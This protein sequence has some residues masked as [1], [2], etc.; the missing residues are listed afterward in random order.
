MKNKEVVL[1]III[2][3]CV[4]FFDALIL[5]IEVLNSTIGWKLVIATEIA[6]VMAIYYLLLRKYIASM[7]TSNLVL[8]I[9]L[10]VGGYYAYVDGAVQYSTISILLYALS[11]ALVVFVF[12]KNL[13]RNSVTVQLPESYYLNLKHQSNE[14]E[15]SSDY[16]K[17]L[18][19]IHNKTYGI[20][21]PRRH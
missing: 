17:A 21:S 1:T 5:S 11:L 12:V 7:V 13:K 19:G 20:V 8:H 3:G 6:T 4:A 2:L 10:M 14:R 9:G 18:T 15:R 16:T